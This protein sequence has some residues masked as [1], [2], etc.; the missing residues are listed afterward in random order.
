MHTY[1]YDKV[2]DSLKIKMYEVLIARRQDP[3]ARFHF[4]KGTYM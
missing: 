2:L 4:S 3:R 1:K